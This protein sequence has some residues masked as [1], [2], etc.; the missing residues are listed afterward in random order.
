MP[1]LLLEPDRLVI[2][3]HFASEPALVSS[4]AREGLSISVLRFGWHAIKS[5]CASLPILRLGPR[6][7]STIRTWG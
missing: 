3:L 1:P 2:D 7:H 6:E 4:L 5:T